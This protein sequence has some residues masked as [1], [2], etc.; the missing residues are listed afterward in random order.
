[1]KSLKTVKLVYREVDEYE[2]FVLGNK[3][4][5]VTP[6]GNIFHRETG[7]AW[8][9]NGQYDNPRRAVKMFQRSYEGAGPE[10][11]RQFNYAIESHDKINE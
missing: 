3:N 8:N 1:M 6:E 9:C 11:K 10:K 4:W 2:E 7:M 5:I